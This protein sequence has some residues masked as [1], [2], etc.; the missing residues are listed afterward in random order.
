MPFPL[1]PSLHIGFICL[2]YHHTEQTEVFEDSNVFSHSSR[3][4]KS[5]I[6]QI[7]FTVVY[8]Q[9]PRPSACA[10]AKPLL[11]S[12]YQIRVHVHDLI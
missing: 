3:T 10:L 1:S 11:I 9:R 8:R 12:L 2:G 7:D 5:K 6:Q 4:W